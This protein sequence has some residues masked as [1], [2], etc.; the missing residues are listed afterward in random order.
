MKPIARIGQSTRKK[1]RS[2]LTC[3][4]SETKYYIKERPISI[5]QLFESWIAAN[6]ERVTVCFQWS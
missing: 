5:E 1:F 3:I 2:F 4:N 6:T